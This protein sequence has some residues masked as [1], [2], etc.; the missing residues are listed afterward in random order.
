MEH[1]AVGNPVRLDPEERPAIYES[2]YIGYGKD[3]FYFERPGF[4][5]LRAAYHAPDGS[6]IVS[7]T[8]RICVRTPINAAEEEIAD[9]LFDEGQGTL[10]YLQGS[11]SR[12]L[13]S[14]N[15][16]FETVLD[17]YAKHPAA[18]HVRLAKGINEARTF[19]SFTEERRLRTRSHGWKKA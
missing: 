18:T 10:F 11:D 5:N 4:Y 19:K 12:F 14:G 17:K 2:V 1:C 9:L 16:A 8:I 7:D 15:D 13:E 3:E 6:L